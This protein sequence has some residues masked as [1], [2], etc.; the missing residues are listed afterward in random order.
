MAILRPDEDGQWFIQNDVDHRPFGIDTYIEQT[1]DSIKIFTCCGAPRDFA[2]SIQINGD[3][4]F[5]TTITGHANLGIGGATIEV[6]ANGRKINPADI[7]SYLPPGGGNFWIDMSMM[8]AGAETG[9][10]DG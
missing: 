10:S 4:Q 8:S 3:D 5:G 7:W 9:S 1:P 2:G 6:R